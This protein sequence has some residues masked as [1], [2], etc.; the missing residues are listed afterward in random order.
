MAYTCSNVLLHKI[1]LIYKLDAPHIRARHPLSW[2]ALTSLLANFR[3]MCPNKCIT[4]Y[5]EVFY[6]NSITSVKLL[7]ENLLTFLSKP[8]SVQVFFD[9]VFIVTRTSIAEMNGTSG[10][11][12]QTHSVSVL[13]QT[14]MCSGIRTQKQFVK[15]S[16]KITLTG[17]LL[18]VLLSFSIKLWA[19][20]PICLSLLQQ[21]CQISPSLC[22]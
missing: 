4:L 3:C 1:F 21:P 14:M 11:T 16:E 2:H 20:L 22:I 6:A 10:E 5:I 17:D 19:L 18:V 9:G 15:N 13:L 12:M 8:C 7:W